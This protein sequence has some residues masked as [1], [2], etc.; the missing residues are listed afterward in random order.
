MGTTNTFYQIVLDAGSS[1]GD[2][3]RGYRVNLSNDGSTWGAPVASGAGTSQVTTISFATNS[4]RYIRVTQTGSTSGWWSIHEFN[5]YGTRGVLPLTPTGL[6]AT[7]GD[8]MVALAW[9]A[10]DTALGY[11]VKRAGAQNG[12]YTTV[13][14]NLAGLSF[15]NSGLVNGTR[16][17]FKVSALNLAGES[18]N[19]AYV[20]AQPVSL[21]PPQVSFVASGGQVQLSWPPDHTTWRLLAQTNAAERGLSSNWATVPGSTVTNQMTFPTDPTVGSVFFRL[22]YP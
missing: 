4:A 2:Y 15:T 21:T 7:A 14:S 1:S 16:Y 13:G 6:A 11:N 12:V 9:N 22:V 20:S 19:S 5:V 17:Y 8:G 10:S 18:T 3:P